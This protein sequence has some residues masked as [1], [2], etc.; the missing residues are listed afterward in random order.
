MIISNGKIK[1][2]MTVSVSE[3]TQILSVTV[4]STHHRCR[5]GG[6]QTHGLNGETPLAALPLREGRASRPVLCS[7]GVDIDNEKYG[8]IDAKRLQNKKILQ[9]FSK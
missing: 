2:T 7:T 8:A 3:L 4:K 5:A 6:E 1:D 9:L